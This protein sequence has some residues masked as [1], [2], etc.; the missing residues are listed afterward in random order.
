MSGY[1]V[2]DP[3]RRASNW[4][5]RRGL[6]EELREQ[7]V[8]GIKGIDTRALTRHLRER[9]A[10]RVGIFSGLSAQADPAALLQRVKASPEMVGADLTGEVSTP[11]PYTSCRAASGRGASTGSPSPRSTSASSR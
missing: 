10:M 4:R 2:R 5:S 11:E 9:G 1:V 8:V 7:G 6:D 3:A